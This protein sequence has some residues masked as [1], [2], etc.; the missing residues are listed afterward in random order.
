MDKPRW[1]ALDA[2]AADAGA[3]SLSTYTS[4][5]PTEPGMTMSPSHM[6]RILSYRAIL[7]ASRT[8]GT[9]QCVYEFQ[10][11]S[12]GTPSQQTGDQNGAEMKDGRG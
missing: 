11:Q 9:Q 2:S 6:R 4:I 3:G 12:R 1:D 8:P 5:L 10:K 7:Y